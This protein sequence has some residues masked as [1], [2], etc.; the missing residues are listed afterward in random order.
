MHVQ[1]KGIKERGN[2]KRSLTAVIHSSLAIEV[3]FGFG[4]A[5]GNPA[6]SGHLV[7]S[8]LA[9]SYWLQGV[10]WKTL[11][12]LSSIRSDI[13]FGGVDPQAG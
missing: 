5:L 8:L 6:D 10:E 11:L 1:L 3:D 7:L 13:F 4:V 9:L 2:P 12:V